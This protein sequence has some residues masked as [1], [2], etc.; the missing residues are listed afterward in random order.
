MGGKLWH[1]VTHASASLSI[2]PHMVVCSYSI[3]IY[4]T[5]VIRQMARL[6]TDQWLQF[7]PGHLAGR[8]K[9]SAVQY[10][11]RHSLKYIHEKSSRKG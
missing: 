5:L 3:G 9:T 1:G 8:K 10:L 6:K 11:H 2:P 4:P 7:S